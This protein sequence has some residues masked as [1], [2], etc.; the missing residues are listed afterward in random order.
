MGYMVFV[1]GKGAPT[2]VHATLE[3]ALTEADRL[4]RTVAP[5]RS[6]HIVQEVAILPKQYGGNPPVIFQDQ[7]A[8]VGVGFIFDFLRRR[9]K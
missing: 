9:T 2:F 5:S 8:K 7:S 4:Q 6:V 3:S 1:Y